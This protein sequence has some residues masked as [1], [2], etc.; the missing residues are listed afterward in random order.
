MALPANFPYDVRRC[1]ELLE[2]TETLATVLHAIVLTAYGEQIYSVDPVELYATIEEDF[3]CTLPVEAENRLQALFLAITTDAFYQDVE[4]FES[5][6][7]ALHSGDIGDAV[8]GLFEQ[9]TMPELLWGL[10]EVELNREDSEQFSAAVG[11]LIAE[12]SQR[13]YSENG[14]QYADDGLEE[15]KVDL[16]TQLRK[17]G[18]PEEVI[19]NGIV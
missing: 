2:S 15:M 10:Y 8:E 14:F 5:I 9:L 13:E 17:L 7:D 11:A 4:A 18:V 16:H 12:V 19:L 1:S 6:C 3:N